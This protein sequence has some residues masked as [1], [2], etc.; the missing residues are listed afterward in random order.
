MGV[1]DIE[2]IEKSCGNNQLVLSELISNILRVQSGAIIH[3]LTLL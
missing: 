1:C 3:S 2:N